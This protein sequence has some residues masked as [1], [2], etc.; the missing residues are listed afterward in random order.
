[1]ASSSSLSESDDDDPV[2]APSNRVWHANGCVLPGFKNDCVFSW[3]LPITKAY[4]RSVN[5]QVLYIPQNSFKHVLMNKNSIT[6][7]TRHIG[8]GIKWDLI[9]YERK[10]GKKEM[11]ASKGWFEFVRANNLKVGDKLQFQICNPPDVLVVEIVRRRTI[12]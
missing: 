6:V 2:F 8:D 4:A 1:M 9:T 7:R 3:E 12:S 5:D 10:T 11:Y